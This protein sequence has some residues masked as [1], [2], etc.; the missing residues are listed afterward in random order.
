MHAKELALI[1][2][3][4]FASDKD[5]WIL[6]NRIKQLELRVEALE[7]TMEGIAPEEYCESKL[8]MMKLYN[9]TGVKCG[10]NS[11]Q[12][13]NAKKAGF[14][15]YETIAYSDCSEDWI[16]TAWSECE[17][18]VQ[19][20]KCVD[21]YDCGTFYKKPE[22]SKE[23]VVSIQQIIGAPFV[24]N[25][26]GSKVEEF[27]TLEYLLTKNYLQV[28]LVIFVSITTVLIVVG[29]KRDSQKTKKFRYRFKPIKS[30]FPFS[31]FK[32][33]SRYRV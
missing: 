11:T 33:L 4:Y 24:P 3:S 20:R 16:C 26:K 29:I 32:K 18:G 10:I 27:I 12:Y 30:S 17:N 6:A 9:L 13:W 25:S 23:C 21:K 31:F 5:V 15:N 2:E 7:R 19:T 28:L 22:E 14:D 1:L 8:D